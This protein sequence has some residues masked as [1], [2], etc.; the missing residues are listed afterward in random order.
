MSKIDDLK[1]KRIILENFIK[2]SSESDFNEDN[3]KKAIA[4]AE[5]DPNLQELIFEDGLISLIK[6]YVDEITLNLEKII[7]KQDGFSEFKIREKISFS[8]F[9]LFELQKNDKIFLKK[10][11]KFYVDLRNLQNSQY[12]IRP[13]ILSFK[14][15]LFLADKIWFFI[16][17]KSTDY[18]YYSK[19]LILSKIIARSFFVFLE[20]DSEDLLK[21]KKHIDSEIEKVMKFEKFKSKIK[22]FEICSQ[23]K[24]DIQENIKDFFI[25]EK[26][27]LRKPVETLKKLP[28]IRLFN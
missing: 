6:F 4:E 9:K 22:N 24:S 18:N 23:S 27:S 17:D 14:N 28:F 10:I 1:T 3:L 21:T 11:S 5:I 16:G 7:K 26:G 13:I 2:I 12:N 15:P 8:L 25:D 20:D 19:R